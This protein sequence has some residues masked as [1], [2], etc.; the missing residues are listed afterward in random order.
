[1]QIYQEEDIDTQNYE[2][3]SDLNGYNSALQINA[4]NVALQSLASEG[5]YSIRA[6]DE[7]NTQIVNDS[8]MIKTRYAINSVYQ[9]KKL[10]VLTIIL[11]MMNN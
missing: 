7:G 10:K 8:I 2:G 11:V 9:V 4:E 6:E 5:W 3:T 1:M